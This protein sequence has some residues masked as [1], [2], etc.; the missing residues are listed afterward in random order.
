MWFATLVASFRTEAIEVYAIDDN[1]YT[2]LHVDERRLKLFVRLSSTCV[3]LFI[4]SF[5]FVQRD[6]CLEHASAGESGKSYRR[7]ETAENHDENVAIV[8]D[9]E[10]SHNYVNTY[11]ILPSISKRN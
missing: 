8:S 1:R 9:G 4:F 5:Q 6:E 10:T 11:V 7:N 3:T 2:G